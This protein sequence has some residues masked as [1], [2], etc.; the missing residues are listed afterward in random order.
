MDR[1][2]KNVG[3]KIAIA[4]SALHRTTGLRDFIRIVPDASYEEGFRFESIITGEPFSN[5]NKAADHILGLGITDYRTFGPSGKA[6]EGITYGASH[7]AQ[8]AKV[9]SEQLLQAATAGTPQRQALA[10]MGLDYLAG[11]Q[12]TVELAKHKFSDQAS[13]KSI[14]SNVEKHGHSMINVNDEGV[15]VIRYMDST[16]RILTTSESKKLQYALGVGSL[17][18][19]FMD[20]ALGGEAAGAV[21]KL[22]KRYKALFNV[23]RASSAGDDLQ[24]VLDLFHARADSVIFKSEQAR[25][26]RRIQRLAIQKAKNRG[27]TVPE[28]ID[29]RA[30]ELQVESSRSYINFQNR[31]PPAPG[32]TLGESTYF[33]D[34]VGSFFKGLFDIASLEKEERYILSFGSGLSQK[35]ATKLALTGKRQL[36]KDLTDPN[37]PAAKLQASLKQMVADMAQKQSPQEI[38]D[39]IKRLAS[40]FSSVRGDMDQFK[41]LIKNIRETATADEDKIYGG[42]AE[43]LFGGIE[44]MR[45]GHALFNDLYLDS[46]IKILKQKLNVVKGRVVGLMGVEEH[47]EIS[48][49]EREIEQFEFMRDHPYHR[50]TVRGASVMP[51][52]GPASQKYE[53]SAAKLPAFMKD[54]AM[55]VYGSSLKKEIAQGNIES[56]LLDISTSGDGPVRVDPLALMYH[57]EYFTDQNLYKN[58]EAMV[59]SGNQKISDFIERGVVPEGVLERIEREATQEI[60]N[61]PALVRA[62]KLRSKALAKNI[63]YMMMTGAKPQEI[64]QLANLVIKQIQNEGFRV[65]DGQVLMTLPDTTRSQ[66]A[67]GASQGVTG[68]VPSVHRKVDF[69]PSAL[70]DPNA[71]TALGISS[72]QPQVLNFMDFEVRDGM[73]LINNASAHLY[74]HALGTFDLDDK[75]LS[76]ALQ[77]TDAQGKGRLAFM[78]NRQPTGFQERIFASTDF[79]KKENVANL[80]RSRMDDSISIF[81]EIIQQNPA[82]LSLSPREMEILEQVK[83]SLVNLKNKS[84]GKRKKGRT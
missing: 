66:I 48:A 80:M 57:Q 62:Q 13:L 63:Q 29:I 72:N 5:I 83:D 4:Q 41:K 42:L 61:V 53:A 20:K 52:I 1:L 23:R 8:E 30:A 71:R 6:I 50:H 64:P 70:R 45:D 3:Q 21:A 39:F 7:I 69:L 81:D 58:M 16:G 9:L 36:I 40:D 35:E 17:N 27:L 34:D 10:R 74:H 54:K 49:L 51:G 22:P 31:L 47:R 67:T 84:K 12:I 79:A 19:S 33:F 75:S 11:E 60:G 2:I 15:T 24:D 38:D 78:T 32:K 28:A 44:K 65:K 59:A 55:I 76:T 37:S 25:F 68:P 14:V 26:D 77:F 82:E 56:L 43:G 18:E 73:M 46:H